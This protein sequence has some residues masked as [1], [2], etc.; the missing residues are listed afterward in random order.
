MERKNLYK[1]DRGN[2]KITVSPEKPACDYTEMYR[3][4]ADEGKILVNGDKRTSCI[5]VDSVEGWE[6]VDDT[7]IEKE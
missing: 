3:L 1:Y 7:E 2:G 6:E 4:I 5:D